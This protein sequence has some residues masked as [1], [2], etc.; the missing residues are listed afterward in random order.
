[1]SV[2]TIELA[3]K[4]LRA[5]SEDL[6]DVQSKLDAAEDA[7][8]QFLNRKLYVDEAALS[9]ALTTVINLRSQCRVVLD[10]ALGAA[11]LIEIVDDRLMAESDAR[12]RY[13]ES[14]RNAA[15]I[16]RG[17]A[18]NKS[19]TAACLLTLGHLWANRE[20]AVTGINP[21]SVIELPHGSRSLLFPYRLD[22]GV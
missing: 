19:I 7:A 17:I 20:D 16:S 3:M 6:D 18:L 22:L 13:A 11:S 21:S 2:I 10:S 12:C 9:A 15:M 1:M 8:E 4:H 5:E 14:L